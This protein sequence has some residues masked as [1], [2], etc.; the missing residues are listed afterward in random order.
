MKKKKLSSF[1]LFFITLF[2][3]IFLNAIELGISPEEIRVDAKVEELGCSNFSLF[4]NVN[5]LGE[6]KWS[7]IET[8]DLRE[9]ILSSEDLDIAINFPDKAKEGKHEIC[10][11]GKRE[12]NYYGVL[13]YKAEGTGYG[14]GT[15]IKL[16]LK[17]DRKT[18]GFTSS[19]FSIKGIK[20]LKENNKI[21]IFNVFLNF[22]TLIFLIY[23]SKLRRK[24]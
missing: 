13:L 14:I 10:F 7:K 24:T 9:Y 12:G 19:G 6:V 20:S 8:K 21:L 1:I 15:W 5:F 22:F 16:N 3:A 18:L 2:N 11:T 4:G 17:E 23:L